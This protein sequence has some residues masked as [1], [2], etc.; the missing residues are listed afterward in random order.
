MRICWAGKVLVNDRPVTKAGTQVAEAA[1]VVINA[2][3][4]K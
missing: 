3:Q 1:R 4:P 2:E